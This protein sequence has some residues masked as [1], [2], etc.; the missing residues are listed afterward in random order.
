MQRKTCLCEI[1]T[2]CCGDQT[3]KLMDSSMTQSDKAFKQ[4]TF[5]VI[6]IG[7]GMAGTVAMLA[8]DKAGVDVCILESEEVLGGTT[9]QSGSHIW[10]PNLS[11]T[12]AIA[13]VVKALNIPLI[14]SEFNNLPSGFDIRINAIKYMASCAYPELFNPDNQYMGLPANIYHQIEVFYDQGSTIFESLFLPYVDSLRVQYNVLKPANHNPLIYDTNMNSLASGFSLTQNH[15][16]T[17]TATADP[18]VPGTFGTIPGYGYNLIETPGHLTMEPDYFDRHN[19]PGTCVG[20]EI[21][22]YE[23]NATSH[24]NLSDGGIWIKRIWDYLQLVRNRQL[25]TNIRVTDIEEKSD[26]IYVTATNTKINQ[27]ILYKARKGVVIAIG[28]FSH[29]NDL[30]SKHLIHA[31]ITATCSA[32]GSRGDLIRIAEKNKWELTQMKHAFF[33]QRLLNNIGT[34]TPSI[35]WFN[36]YMSHMVINKL[37]RRVYKETAAYNE[38]T[39][40]HFS[41]DPAYSYVNECLFMVIDRFEYNIFNNIALQTGS[42]N[43]AK[44][45]SV[46]DPNIPITTKIQQICSDIQTWFQSLPNLADFGIN[47]TVMANGFIETLNKY[48]TYCQTGIDLEFEKHNSDLGRHFLGYIRSFLTPL[49]KSTPITEFNDWRFNNIIVEALYGPTGKA[50]FDQIATYAYTFPSGQTLNICPDIL[51][52]PIIDPVV[53]VL[54]PCTLDTKGGP[55]TNSELKI[56]YSKGSF[57]AG[58]CGGNAFTANGYFGAGAILG[59]SLMEGWIAGSNASNNDYNFNQDDIFSEKIYIHSLMNNEYPDKRISLVLSDSV[60]VGF[61]TKQAPGNFGVL[62]KLSVDLNESITSDIDTIYLTDWMPLNRQ[63]IN[64]EDNYDFFKVVLPSNTFPNSGIYLISF[65]L[66]RH[67]GRSLGPAYAT[68]QQLNIIEFNNIYNNVYVNTVPSASI[69]LQQAGSSWTGK[70]QSTVTGFP[71]VAD[72]QNIYIQY[73]QPSHNFNL[74]HGFQFETLA[75]VQTFSTFVYTGDNQMALDAQVVMVTASSTF[76]F[77]FDPNPP[78]GTKPNVVIVA[79]LDLAFSQ[80]WFNTKYDVP[81]NGF[82]FPKNEVSNYAYV[83]TDEITKNWFYNQTA[84]QPTKYT[85]Y[86]YYCLPHR[87]TLNHYG[88]FLVTP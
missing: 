41:W 2:T 65:Q 84:T 42:F 27:T 52:Q 83:T 39:K 36:W 74:S 22:L 6:V 58:N 49:L 76:N 69:I 26:G 44:A 62:F 5:D 78:L 81:N 68:Q 33:N 71:Q 43:N 72:G 59:P 24:L 4:T 66:I 64:S 35:M 34:P 85:V 51:L 30:I 79:N 57:V 18:I 55:I 56:S 1:N 16:Q 15:D 73:K 54:V 13:T 46:S 45:F 23:N 63:I 80:P 87:T 12:K 40:V 88:W 3:I 28:G 32:N 14:G 77:T 20:R 17:F 67:N 31:K 25:L 48:H 70:F 7:S 61:V 47:S 82:T 8:A 10:F 11:K 50:Y 60:N 29:N 9:V 75:D 53:M 86:F 38:R 37:G 21:T 19:K